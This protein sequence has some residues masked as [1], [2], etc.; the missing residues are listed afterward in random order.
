MT[1]D[2]SAPPYLS[3][4]TINFA[5]GGVPSRQRRGLG[6]RRGSKP[7]GLIVT[8]RPIVRFGGIHLR[9]FYELRRF[10][11]RR[12]P[13]GLRRS[14]G[15]AVIERKQWRHACRRGGQG[16]NNGISRR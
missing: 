5:F 13:D 16:S 14:R 3:P 11:W 8:I 9:W 4:V 6:H 1:R 7:E 2:V 15:K 12:R 10:G